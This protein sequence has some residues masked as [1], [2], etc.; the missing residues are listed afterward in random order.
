MASLRS[1]L[2]DTAELLDAQLEPALEIEL[3]SWMVSSGLAKWP[4]AE[5][6]VHEA[7]L[8]LAKRKHPF[9][10]HADLMK[11]LRRVATNLAIDAIRA[12]GRRPTASLDADDGLAERLESVQEEGGLTVVNEEFIGWLLECIDRLPELQRQAVK[13]HLLKGLKARDIARDRDVSPKTIHGLLNKGLDALRQDMKR[14]A[15][16]RED[17]ESVERRARS[18]PE[19]SE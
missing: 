6:I 1:A 19:K 10:T 7:L 2:H 15:D 14:K 5:D 17:I 12:R 18:I 13:A 9:P 16:Y 4:D 11:F 3:I 8:R